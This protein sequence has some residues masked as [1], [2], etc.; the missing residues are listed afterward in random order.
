MPKNSGAILAT[1]TLAV[2]AVALFMPFWG[3]A[4]KLLPAIFG[5]QILWVTLVFGCAFVF[6]KKYLWL[7]L[8]AP[9]AL[10]WPWTQALLIMAVCTPRDCF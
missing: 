2:A 4:K 1:M 9:F 5:L 7:L 8:T 10:F 3:D 6:R